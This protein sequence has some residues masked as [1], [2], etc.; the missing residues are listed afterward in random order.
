MR[1][2]ILSNELDWTGWTFEGRGSI[3]SKLRKPIHATTPSVPVASG[4][5]RRPSFGVDRRPE[6]HAEQGDH[7]VEIKR[8]VPLRTPGKA[9]ALPPVGKA[10]DKATVRE[11]GR[12]RPSCSSVRKSP[13]GA[14]RSPAWPG[15]PRGKLELQ[16]KATSAMKAEAATVESVQILAIMPKAAIPAPT[17]A[18]AVRPHRRFPVVRT[19]QSVNQPPKNAATAPGTS[20]RVVSRPDRSGEAP[21]A[22]CK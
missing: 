22:C 14:G 9:R 1:F 4:H 11:S 20:T 10:A 15:P 21:R 6:N 2:G 17:T 5:D 19:S 13:R 8:R 12:V 7:H 18:C 3:L 16:P